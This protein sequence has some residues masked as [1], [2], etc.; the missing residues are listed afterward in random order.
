MGVWTEGLPLEDLEEATLANFIA[1]MDIWKAVD[2]D[3]NAMTLQRRSR[4]GNQVNECRDFGLVGSKMVILG[5]DVARVRTCRVRSRIDPN[6]H[7]DWLQKRKWGLCRR[8]L[9]VACRVT[10]LEYLKVPCGRLGRI[11]R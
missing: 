7:D 2:G 10:W 8:T 4:R 9:G 5:A 3:G 6:K 11:G 1:A